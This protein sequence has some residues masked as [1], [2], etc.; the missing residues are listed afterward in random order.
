MLDV[1]AGAA[2]VV[3]EIVLLNSIDVEFTVKTP[4]ETGP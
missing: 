2:N 4:V 1:P 3:P